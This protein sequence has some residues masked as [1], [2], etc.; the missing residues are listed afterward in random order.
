MLAGKST[1]TRALR[2]AAIAALAAI[3]AVAAAAAPG[4]GAPRK[5]KPRRPGPTAPL[6]HVGRWITDAR[7][8][9]VILHG[10]NMVY[11][12][13]PY[14]PGAVGFDADDAVFLRRHGFNNVRLGTIYGAVEPQPGV[15]DDA[16]LDQIGRTQELLAAEGLFTLLDMHQDQYALK[17]SGRGFPAWAA[18][19][20]GLP[21]TQQGFPPAI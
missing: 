21:N 8:R 17:Y 10:V 1:G 13:P 14:H 4:L 6:S 18:L 12:R 20:D 9:V 3:V 16:Y 19:D 15:Y 11:K 5:P 7:G 2:V